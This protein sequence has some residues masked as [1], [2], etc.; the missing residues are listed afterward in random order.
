MEESGLNNNAECEDLVSESSGTG[1]VVFG[2]FCSSEDGRTP[3]KVDEAVT[4][5]DSEESE[6]P[7]DDI[8]IQGFVKG[9][10]S[11]ASH[12]FLEKRD[13]AMC[14]PEALPGLTS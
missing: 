6:S 14:A 10:S 12:A 2:S 3:L 13:V 8:G 9:E 11:A 1:H 4:L 5:K 7:L